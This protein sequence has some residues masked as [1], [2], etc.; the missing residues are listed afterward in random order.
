MH[1]IEDDNEIDG[2]RENSHTSALFQGYIWETIWVVRGFIIGD[3]ELITA[4]H[5]TVN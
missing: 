4:L 1:Y 3:K 5:C 2:G